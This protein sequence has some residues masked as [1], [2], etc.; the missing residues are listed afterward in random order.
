MKTYYALAAL[1]L[2]LAACSPVDTAVEEAAFP[3]ATDDALAG[4]EFARVPGA[5]LTEMR[6]ALRSAMSSM[7]EIAGAAESWEDAHRMAQRHIA[8]AE[9][10]LERKAVSQTT[11]K[12]LLTGFL[13][14]NDHEEGTS[15]L[16]LLYANTLVDRASPEA[17]TVLS[18]LRA[19][20]DGW[21]EAERRD[22]A[23]GAADAA[24]AHVRASA[25]CDG[26][27]VPARMQGAVGDHVGAMDAVSV[28]RLE[29][30]RQLRALAR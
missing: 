16:A 23:L 20:G 26:C 12:L 28:R 2:S 24:E 4:I 7:Y 29:A 15:E 27:E 8:Q 6:G 10:E 22:V 13:I 5:D 3:V 1:A 18:T 11:A 21:S 19:F 25:A 30:A 17:E 9:T 14:P